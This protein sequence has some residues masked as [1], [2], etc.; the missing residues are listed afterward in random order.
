MKIDTAK[1]FMPLLEP[2]RDKGAWGGR[3]SGK[4]HFMVE[5]LVEQASSRDVSITMRGL[6]RPAISLANAKRSSRVISAHCKARRPPKRAP[7]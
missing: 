2:A 6:V 3:G 1:A 4:S 7:S 5:A